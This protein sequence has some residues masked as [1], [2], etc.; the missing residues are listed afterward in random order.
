MRFQSMKT[1]TMKMALSA[2]ALAALS[3]CVNLAPE[4]ERPAAPVASRFEGDTADASTAAALPNWQAFYSDARLQALV[5]LALKNNRDL[6]AAVL[7]AE[8]AAQ[9][10]RV[11]DASRW[12]TVG[13]GLIASRQPTG[14]N[15]ALANS[16][17]AGL[18]V[19]SYELDL[20]GRLKSQTDAAAARYL[21]SQEGARA[22]QLSLV[23][24]VASSYYALQADEALLDL[25]RR[26]EAS[27]ADS[28]KLVKL[29]YD[30]GA[31]SS[32][33]MQAA[34][35]ALESARAAT[36]QAVRQRAQDENALVLLLGQSVPKDLPGASSLQAQALQVLAP[37]VPSS[38]LTQRPDVLQAE[39]QL[40]AAEAN[41]GAARAAFFPAITL[42]SSVGTASGQLSD[43]FKNTVWTFTGQALAPI[44]DAGR[45]NANLASA[46][47]GRD[48]AVAQYEK[49]VQQAF[50]DVADALVARSTLQ[51][52][53]RAQEAQAGAATELLRLV[54]LRFDQ[55]AAS[56]LELLDAQRNSFAAEQAALQVRLA[57]LQSGVQ[58]Y[59]SLGGGLTSEQGKT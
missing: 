36:A 18:Q 3:A 10:V 33:D 35:S 1:R 25:A 38:V 5:D 39:A 24:G 31:A 23:A 21:A 57:A 51:D 40:V 56:S 59:K 17:Q 41:I 13:A 9:L 16:Y 43:L 47:I 2:V 29:R 27:R 26:T 50:R 55:G 58:L 4:H 52:Q 19:N 20:W 32:V 28:H 48:I 49:A 54:Q 46:K 30:S 15:G 14:A 11:T 45:N 22:A 53:L 44:F 7:N 8:Q 42:S 34:I 6:R 37:G 12:P